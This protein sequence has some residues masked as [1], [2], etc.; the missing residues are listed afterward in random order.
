[1]ENIFQRGIVLAYR[2][3]ER[4]LSA[5]NTLKEDYALASM[6]P[7]LHALLAEDGLQMTFPVFLR[8]NFFD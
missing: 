5:S 8:N 2:D 3:V 6:G 4:L 1:M 7:N